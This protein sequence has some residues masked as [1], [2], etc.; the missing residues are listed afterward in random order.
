[1]VNL[2][3]MKSKAFV[4]VV[5]LLILG[6]SACSGVGESD[7]YSSEVCETLAIKVER[8]DSLTQND[9]AQMIEQSEQILR[10]LVDKSHQIKDLTEE[11]RAGKIRWIFA[12]HDCL[13]QFGYLFTL[14]TAL[15]Q[16]NEAGML[17]SANE[18]KYHKLDKYNSELAEL[19]E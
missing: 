6:L 12:D 10:H 13:E 4:A 2:Q 18:R 1:M 14:G 9:Y 16:A 3:E 17:D 7:T 15:Y 8:H 5:V 11:E 19:I